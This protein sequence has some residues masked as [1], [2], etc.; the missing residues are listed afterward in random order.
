MLPRKERRGST[1]AFM[2]PSMY[3]SAASALFSF[4][5]HGLQIPSFL[6]L[7][8]LQE[9]LQKQVFCA[10]LYAATSTT[11]FNG[12]RSREQGLW[13]DP[14]SA[15]SVRSLSTEHIANRFLEAQETTTPMSLAPQQYVSMLSLI[16]GVQQTSL[17]IHNSR[18]KLMLAL[19]SQNT[20]SS[21]AVTIGHPNGSPPPMQ[22]PSPMA[23]HQGQQPML[24]Q[25]QPSGINY[26]QQLGMMHQQDPNQIPM[27]QQQHMYG[28]PPPQQ[29]QGGPVPNGQPQ[30]MGG[31]V[32]NPA[33]NDGSQFKTATAIPNLGMG[34]SPVDCPSCGKRGM[35]RISYHPGNTTQ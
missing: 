30:Q 13:Y 3:F 28:Q 22:S 29:Y 5:S 20:P 23:Q 11:S 27:Q 4:Q 10:E 17:P 2:P 1:L 6:D 14:S 33:Q 31:G 15:S 9:I 32:S 18:R 7:C 16:L 34:P 8:P 35:T 19:F 24:Y 21:Q 25:Q 26:Q 12:V